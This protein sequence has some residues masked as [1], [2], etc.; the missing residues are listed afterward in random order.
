MTKSSDPAHYIVFHPDAERFSVSV[1]AAA[2][3]R[4]QQVNS[5]AG[6]VWVDKPP[7]NEDPFVLG[8]SWAYSYCHATELRRQPRKTGGYVTRGS[9]ILF[10]SGD[11][12]ER[13]VL[14]VDTVFWI[15]E[16]HRWESAN[17]PADRYAQ[18]VRGRTDIWKFHLQFGGQPDGHKGMYTYEAALHQQPGNRYSHLPVDANGERVRVKLSELSTDLRNRITN[19]LRGKRPVPLVSADLHAILQLLD[20]RTNVAVVGDLVL[21]DPVFTTFRMEE[22]SGCRP[23][24]AD[25]T[26]AAAKIGRRVDRARRTCS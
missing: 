10:C 26:Y 2:I 23:S 25:T 7:G 11:L 3:V 22:S 1:R 15:A 4:G 21:D 19:K 24:H 6:K 18:D 13:G 20:A 8:P 14:A 5:W 17:A 16:A 12:G 9:C